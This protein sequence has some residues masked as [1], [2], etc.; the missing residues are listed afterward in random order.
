MFMD[1]HNNYVKD[2]LTN[3]NS[4]PKRYCNFIK[5]KKKENTGV[6]PLTKDGLSFCDRQNQANIM[7]N[8][9]YSVFI[10][11]DITDLPDLGPSNTQSAPQI[12]D[13][14]NIETLD[15]F[16]APQSCWP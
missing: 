7:G 3:D 5:S 8:Q 12:K 15:G 2:I 10:K 6:S 11:E 9:F 14:R 4:N 1:E 13:K 16:E